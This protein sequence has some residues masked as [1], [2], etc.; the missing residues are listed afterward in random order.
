MEPISA[1]CGQN[2]EFALNVEAASNHCALTSIW[3][4]FF[5]GASFESSPRAVHK[6]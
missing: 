2:A 3:P 4:V 5:K 1:L 6:V